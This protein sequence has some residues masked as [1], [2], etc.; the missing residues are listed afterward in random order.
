MRLDTISTIGAVLAVLTGVLMAFVM[1]QSAFPAL[2]YAT[3]ESHYIDVSTN[4]GQEYSS[5][6]WGNRSID[7]L[8]QAFAIFAAAAGCLAMLR[9][10]WEI[11][12]GK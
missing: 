9:A 10:G 12:E 7:L 1:S 2:E 5:F 8:A 11:R 3:S 4:V 6:L